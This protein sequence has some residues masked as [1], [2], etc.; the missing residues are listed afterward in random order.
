MS[1]IPQK[2]VLIER[3]LKSWKKII[4]FKVKS[5]IFEPRLKL[6]L[7]LKFLKFGLRTSLN[8][9]LLRRTKLFSIYYMSPEAKFKKFEPWLK[10]KPRVKYGWF[11]LKLYYIIQDLS[12]R[13]IDTG[14]WGILDKTN[15]LNS[16]TH[17]CFL[18]TFKSKDIEA[19]RS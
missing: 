13:S 3:R 17:K 16:D 10:F 19:T 8:A 4:Q 6:K 7:R 12:R 15:S 11:Y 2:P 18:F 9:E 14:F 5:T 1:D